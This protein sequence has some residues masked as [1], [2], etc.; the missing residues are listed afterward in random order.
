MQLDFLKKE[1]SD[2]KV[3]LFNQN[4][5]EWAYIKNAACEEPV[6]VYYEPEDITP[7]CLVFA[8]Q[9]IHISNEQELINDIQDFITGKRTAIEF[10]DDNENYI[11][12]GDIKTSL[13]DNLTIDKLRTEFSLSGYNL[14]KLTFK[15]VCQNKKYCLKGRF[16]KDKDGKN[17]II[18]E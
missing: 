13:L 7:Y 16:I 18:I 17:Q 4:D 2:Y 10:I 1:F 11:F 9:H 6:R 3:E 5:S 8:T 14:K 12:G 15:T